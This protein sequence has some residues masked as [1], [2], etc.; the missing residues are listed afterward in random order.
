MVKSGRDM[1]SVIVEVDETFVG[2]TES[3]SDKKGRGAATKILVVV[4]TECIGKQI[5]RV[6]FRCIDAATVEN[7]MPSIQDNVVQGS[8]IVTDGWKG[9]KPLPLKKDGQ[10][11]GYIHEVK[12]IS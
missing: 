11:K 12:T 5:G 7:L 3:G 4:A 8:T 1:L 9:Y 6:R 2:G 10:E